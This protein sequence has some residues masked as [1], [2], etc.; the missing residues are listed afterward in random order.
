M[1]RWIGLLI[2]CLAVAPAWA[3]EAAGETA[4]AVPAA[5]SPDPAPGAAV[6]AGRMVSLSTAYHTRFDAYLGAG[7]ARHSVAV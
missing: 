4:P 5:E 6:A 1:S 2:A 7:A 3:E